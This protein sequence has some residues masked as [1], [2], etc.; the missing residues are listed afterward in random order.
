MALVV[1]LSAAALLGSTDALQPGVV[2]QPQSITYSGGNAT[3]GSDFAFTATGEKS[4]IL[5]AA[6][7]RYG[8]LLGVGGSVGGM[9]DRHVGSAG[10]SVC[11]VDVA[12]PSLS[13]DLETDESY[14]LDLDATKCAIVSETVFGAMHG[15]E[16]LTQL[17][18][19]PGSTAPAVHIDDKP[20]FAFRATMIDTAR[21]Y[22]PL[23]D[24]LAHLDAMA[25]TKMNVLHWHI[26]D[27]E[28][29]PYESK[30]FPQLSEHGAYHPHEV[31]TP[32]DIAKVVSYAT[33]R[34]IRV[35]SGHTG[36]DSGQF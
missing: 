22:Y 8:K 27:I 18:Q 30:A 10:L 20:R 19:R 17:V 3:L 35:R 24:I 6:I 16:S 7:A 23:Q 29:F 28:S 32:N 1:V 2:P 25:A 26:V 34:G 33:D 31:Y 36:V 5:S 15:M 13:L 11:T 9:V 21:H 12:H 4:A 14:T